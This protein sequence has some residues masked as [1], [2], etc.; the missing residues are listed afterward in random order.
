MIDR[1]EDGIEIK[2][3]K[4]HFTMTVPVSLSTTFYTLV[5]QYVRKMSFL[6][7]EHA[8]T[9]YNRTSER[10]TRGIKFIQ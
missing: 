5:F 10:D 9:S 7:L 3:G 6:T 8:R 2:T 4:E 1:F